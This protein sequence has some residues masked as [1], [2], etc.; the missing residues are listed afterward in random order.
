MENNYKLKN[1]QNLLILF[2]KIYPLQSEKNYY[3]KY[4]H[5]F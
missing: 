4:F 3:D 5:G 2:G 1:V